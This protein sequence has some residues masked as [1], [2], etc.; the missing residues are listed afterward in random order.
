MNY[1]NL[2]IRY[3]QF[4]ERNLPIDPNRRGKCNQCLNCCKLGF[5]CPF[6]ITY[7][8]KSK[9]LI[10]RYRPKQCR[11]SPRTKEFLKPNCGFY[12]I[13][14]N[15]NMTNQKTIIQDEMLKEYFGI[16]VLSISKKD[17]VISIGFFGENTHRDLEIDVSKKEL[18][19]SGSYVSI[20]H[21][22]E[23]KKLLLNK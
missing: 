22:N 16:E 1:E 21:M 7:K 8:S 11:K 15:K 5:R 4:K 19:G 9:C 10:Y 14:E 20:E 17:N 23:A 6:L 3:K 13:E 2:K 18:I 12:F